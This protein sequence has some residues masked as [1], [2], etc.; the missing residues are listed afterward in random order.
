MKDLRIA[1]SVLRITYYLMF[2]LLLAQ[3]L[4]AAF[5]QTSAPSDDDV[6]RIAKQLYC[7][8][9]ENTPLDVCPTQACEEWRA[10]I[11]RMLAEGKTEEEIKQY[12]VEYYGARVLAEPPRQGFNWLAYIVPPL[13][14]LLGIF[15]LASGFRAWKKPLEAE[16]GA[17]TFEPQEDAD[18]Y[19]RRLEE[20]LHKRK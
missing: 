20:E 11:R 14:I 12:F 5:A 9:C 8:V 1:H 4:W 17:G 13:I 6:N 7:P 10:Q 16:A 19:V 18:E 15:M 2:I 3:P